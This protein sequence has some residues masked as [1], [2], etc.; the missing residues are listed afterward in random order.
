[1]GTL[2]WGKAS[3]IVSPTAARRSPLARVAFSTEASKRG[4]NHEIQGRYWRMFRRL[5]LRVA[6]VGAGHPGGAQGLPDDRNHYRRSGGR[7]RRSRRGAGAARARTRSPSSEVIDV[8]HHWIPPHQ[9][10]DL[11]RVA[12]PGQSVREMRPGTMGLFRGSSM[13]FWCNEQISSVDRLIA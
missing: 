11:A 7:A 1:M 9:A 8:H 6:G 10:K 13:L 3:I 5:V 2:V 4:R 12:L